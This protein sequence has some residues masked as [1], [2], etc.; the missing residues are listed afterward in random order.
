MSTRQ[1][2]Y[3]VLPCLILIL[4]SISF[5]SADATEK[6]PW[7]GIHIMMDT[8]DKT[9]QLTDAVKGLAK[10]GVNTIVAE[11]NYGY[12]Y[13]S[14]PNLRSPNAIS[15][16]QL[17]ELLAQCRKNNI[18]LIPQFQ[19]FGHQSWKGTTYPLL[20]QYPEFGETPGKYPD[21]KGIYC[22]SW[23]P[24]HP[25]VNPIVF[26][27]MDELIEVL[28][29]DAFHV[30]MDEIFLIAED[31]CPRCKGKGK[32]EIFAK[33]I[34]DYHKHIVDKHKIEMLMW[35]DRLIDSS[36]INY[37]SWEAS[38]N[39]TA[40]AIDLI[41]RDIIICDWHYELRAAYESVPMFLKK[42]F[43][44]W[45]A[46][47]LKPEAAKSLIDYS[48]KQNNPKMVG[49]LN[50]TWGAVPIKALSG[51]EPLRYSTSAF[52][53]QLPSESPSTPDRGTLTP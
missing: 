30:G 53:R 27:L 15:K 33:A 22:R 45:P 6:Y 7:L 31:S 37:G 20:I 38:A 40:K 16:K 28:Q 36:K 1:R 29:A 23:C 52:S 21:N 19:C 51:F 43:R 44:V 34:N 25:E 11:I 12:E 32:A 47:W 18:R 48:L 49:H 3:T 41:P 35:G 10:L 13:Q 26:D 42:G 17:K 39:N 24:L 50:T 14:H 9:E 46:S 4:S 2:A 5:C 8:G